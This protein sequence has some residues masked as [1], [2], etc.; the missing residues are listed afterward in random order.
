M[1]PPTAVPASAT[2]SVMPSPS[3]SA[4]RSSVIVSIVS[5]PRIFS[6]NPAPRVS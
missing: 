3:S 1:A 6:E 2:F 4:I 5:G